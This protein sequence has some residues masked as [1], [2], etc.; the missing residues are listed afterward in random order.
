MGFLFFVNFET[1]GEGES[2][3]RVFAENAGRVFAENAGRR[4]AENGGRD[5]GSEWG[6]SKNGDK[7]GGRVEWTRAA[8]PGVFNLEQFAW[9]FAYFKTIWRCE[10]SIMG[11]K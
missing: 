10:I 7:N 2:G 8:G 6:K 1:V 5:E 4:F 9:N 3:W 11:Q